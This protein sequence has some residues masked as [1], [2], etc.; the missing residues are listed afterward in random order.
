MFHVTVQV[1][2]TNVILVSC[3]VHMH[4]FNLDGQWTPVTRAGLCHSRQTQSYVANPH[5]STPV[6]TGPEV[7]KT[8]HAA[9]SQ[10]VCAKNK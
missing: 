5:L 3:G 4:V 6:A 9:A 7:H 8:A 10:I 2:S 1:H